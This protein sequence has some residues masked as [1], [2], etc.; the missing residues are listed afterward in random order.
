MKK[1]IRFSSEGIALITTLS[2]MVIL[3]I[4]SLAVVALSTGNLHT[5]SNTGARFYA[6]NLATSASVYAM[7]DIQ[8]QGGNITP[9]CPNS[10][11]TTATLSFADNNYELTG[12]NGMPG[13]FRVSYVNNLNNPHNTTVASGPSFYS[14]LVGTE[15]YGETAVIVAQGDY[16][17][18]K[19][20]V[21]STVKYM[22]CG[23]GADGVI[24]INGGH[25]ILNGIEDFTTFRPRSGSF[26]AKGG[27][28]Y[29]NLSSARILNGSVLSS[30]GSVVDTS[31]TSIIDRRFVEENCGKNIT[32]P[33]WNIGDP[34]MTEGFPYDPNRYFCLDETNY[35][36]LDPNI[37]VT[38]RSSGLASGH[39]SRPSFSYT[40]SI[41]D[42]LEYYMPITSFPYFENKNIFVNGSLFIDGLDAD[43]ELNNCNLFVN[44]ILIINGQ[45]WGVNNS[46]VFV[47]GYVNDMTSADPLRPYGL[48][49]LMAD[50][51]SWL[52]PDDFNYTGFLNF[53]T[54]GDIKITNHTPDIHSAGANIDNWIRSAPQDSSK[55]CD[56]FKMLKISESSNKGANP[57]WKWYRDNT[58]G[59][60]IP[61]DVGDPG[62]DIL[63]GNSGVDLTEK[64]LKPV[65]DEIKDW[66]S[67]A[68]AYESMNWAT[69]DFTC[70]FYSESWEAFKR[71]PTVY[72]ASNNVFHVGLI[73]THGNFIVE[74]V[75]SPIS[76]VG[77]V[78]AKKNAGSPA[79]HEGNIILK[80]GSSIIYCP[81][82]YKDISGEITIKPVLT[83]YS[84]EEL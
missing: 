35:H 38:V 52:E 14:S 64:G 10:I 27:I 80:N 67:M 26:Y 16:G 56:V 46:N 23:A 20:T 45:V 74:S 1:K 44:G 13:K 81:E 39:I 32:L 33:D 49:F 59:G 61:L 11:P 28:N 7:Y 5:T 31:G 84:W 54:E 69:H 73:F 41:D 12:M 24:T 62:Q 29:E 21:K 75:I 58:A 6:L 19:R 78:I 83:V 53:F 37:T 55:I 50:V 30:D 66:F 8:S 17:G 68:D 18:F 71:N 51:S 47:A 43:I 77:S 57:A 70:S 72:N 40:P 42:S 76:L 3:L 82:L 34:N 36:I 79:G 48:S 65:P 60:D 22:E 2:I 15:V 25:F 63:S 9:F 4:V